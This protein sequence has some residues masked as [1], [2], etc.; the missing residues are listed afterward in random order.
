MA[1]NRAQTIHDL[2]QKY[3]PVVQLGPHELSFSGIDTIKAI[4]EGQ[5]ECAKGPIYDT[6]GRTGLFSMQDPVAH[7]ERRRL[8]AHVFAQ[9][10]INDMEPIIREQVQKLIAVIDRKS[11]EGI[12]VRQWFRMLSLDISGE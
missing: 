10:N 2:H 7:K 5:G 12:D 9:G 1:G 6:F 3:G 4:Y 11:P 8:M